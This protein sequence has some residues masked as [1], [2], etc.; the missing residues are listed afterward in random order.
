MACA[1]NRLHR[2]L[3]L[4]TRAYTCSQ[5]KQRHHLKGA[6]LS[7]EDEH[8]VESQPSFKWGFPLTSH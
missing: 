4:L 7:G 8:D 2:K 5:K 6:I 3:A 1:E